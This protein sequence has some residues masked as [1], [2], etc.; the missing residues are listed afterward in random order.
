VCHLLPNLW[1]ALYNISE[2]TSVDVQQW[3]LYSTNNLF[4]CP[5]TCSS[6]WFFHFGEE[7]I[8]ARTHIG[9]VERMF[10]YLPLPATYCRSPY[11]WHWKGSPSPL[12]MGDTRISA[13]ISRYQSVRLWSLRQI[14]RTT[15]RDKLRYKRGYYASCRAVTAGHQQKWTRRWCTK[16]ST[17][18]AQCG[19]HGGD[20]IEGI[21]VWTR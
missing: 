12:A 14:G 21:C 4:S 19:T 5:V 3:P 16:P 18:L 9:W 13:I 15:A 6:Q 8:T 7:I 2:S 1:K 10:P 11:C 17:N 20:Y